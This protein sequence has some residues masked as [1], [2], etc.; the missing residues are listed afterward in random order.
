MLATMLDTHLLAWY[1]QPMKLSTYLHL[2]EVSQS[3]LARAAGLDHSTVSRLVRDKTRP[4][5]PAMEAIAKATG[6]RV[7]PND[8]LNGPPSVGLSV[9]EKLPE[10]RPQVSK[11]GVGF[12]QHPGRDNEAHDDAPLLDTPIRHDDVLPADGAHPSIPGAN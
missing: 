2:E 6:W 1:A 7:M 12:D 11:L 3:R 5:W 8:F 4:N 9:R 10:V